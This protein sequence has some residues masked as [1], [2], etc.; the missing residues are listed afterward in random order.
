MKLTYV[1]LSLSRCFALALTMD[2]PAARLARPKAM[3]RSF[4]EAREAS[5]GE[6]GCDVA[7]TNR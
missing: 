7:V 2:A 6:R 1:V 5:S 3:G 4:I